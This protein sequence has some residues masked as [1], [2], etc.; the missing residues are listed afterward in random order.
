MVDQLPNCENGAFLSGKM[1]WNSNG[2]LLPRH[3]LLPLGCSLSCQLGIFAHMASRQVRENRGK[4]SHLRAFESQWPRPSCSQKGQLCTSNGSGRIFV[5]GVPQPGDLTSTLLAT[6]RREVGPV[7]SPLI[8][9][10]DL[11]EENLYIP[12]ILP[13]ISSYCRETPWYHFKRSEVQ[14]YV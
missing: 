13:P 11:P 6:G 10:T 2:F 9:T 7:F 1:F 8:N 12:D 14:V 4:R 5:E 3:F